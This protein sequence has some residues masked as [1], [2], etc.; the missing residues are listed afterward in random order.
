MNPSDSHQEDS[1]IEILRDPG[2]I[3]AQRSS[4]RSTTPG[5]GQ[6]TASSPEGPRDPQDHQPT[7][8]EVTVDADGRHS[9]G[10][11]LHAQRLSGTGHRGPVFSPVDLS[12]MPGQLCVVHGGSGTGKSSLL[13]ALAA[14]WRSSSGRLL[15]AGVD[16][17]ADPYAAA[18]HTSVARIGRY[19]APD[20]QLSIADLIT[21]HSYL[22]GLRAREGRRRAE[23]IEDHLGV[24][25][26]RGALLCDLVPVEAT[27]VTVAL[28]MLRQAAVVVADDVDRGVAASE[29]L[30][31]YQRL[32]EL[33][34]LQ[35]SALIVT[36]NDASAA[37]VGSL[38]VRLA[39][40]KASHVTHIESDR[41]DVDMVA[42]APQPIPA[43]DAGE[44]SD[45]TVITPV[46]EPPAAHPGSAAPHFDSTHRRQWLGDEGN[47][48][49]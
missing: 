34:Q 9:D 32:Q 44:R 28:A 38:R 10:S 20:D 6:A 35:D 16:A 2:E 30:V 36:A 39:A 4:G 8:D 12:V 15:I 33:A 40:R 46:T 17:I 26:E 47:Q 29:H 49:K 19:V 14:R 42:S 21:Q 13:L 37:P 27:L 45:A 7:A 31:L 1:G 25:V 22:S 24:R 5:N 41:V 43:L 11:V 23:D 18:Q 3:P 48:E